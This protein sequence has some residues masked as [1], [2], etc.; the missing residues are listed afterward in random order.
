MR[1]RK[2]LVLDDLPIFRYG[3][4]KILEKYFNVSNLFLDDKRSF[5]VNN[6][7]VALVG[8]LQEGYSDS[9]ETI[10]KL[11]SK[12]LQIMTIIFL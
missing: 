10:K 6:V 11:N 5:A 12:S 4:E 1:R 7:S 8:V 3:L 9:L 2:I